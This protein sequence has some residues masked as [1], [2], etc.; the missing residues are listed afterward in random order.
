MVAMEVTPKT[1]R[2]VEFREKMR[3][4]HPE[5]VDH[6]L[7][8]VA[9]GVES[10]IDR[11][12]QAI[13]RAQRAE[14]AA[15]DSGSADDTLRKTLVLAQRTAD[16]AVQEAREQ[17]SRI[18][19][20]AEQQAQA[21]L[22]DAEERGRRLMEDTLA[23]SRVE[24]GRLESQRAQSQKDVD[25]LTRWVDEHKAH[26]Q[27]TLAEALGAVERAGV[28]WAAPSTRP[29]DVPPAPQPPAPVQAAPPVA[30]PAPPPPPE[31]DPGPET[32]MWHP[33]DHERMPDP[34][35]TMAYS[36]PPPPAPGRGEPA[37]MDMTDGPDDQALDDFFDDS[38]ELVDD[39]RFGGRLRRRR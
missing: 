9:V 37:N 20:G 10:L 8:E 4:Y 3:G 5:D 1:L 28:L 22:A 38:G 33:A 35:A 30:A 27:Q 34:D 26:L 21:I 14:A 25:G 39:R 12:R 15:S 18:L 29:F 7:E 23:E 16:M 19:G 31:H 2:E 17:A 36:A 32:A 11:V 6:F 13:E 24:L